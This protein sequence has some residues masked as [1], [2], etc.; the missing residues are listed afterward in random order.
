MKSASVLIVGGGIVGASIAWHLA[1]RGWRDI[2]IADRGASPGTGSSARSLGAFR[3]NFG[4]Q[5]QVRLALLSRAKLERFREETG[6]DA[7]YDDAGHLWVASSAEDLERLREGLRVQRSEGVLSVRELGPDDVRRINPALAEDGIV[8]G[9]YCP[10]DGFFQPLRVLEGYLAAAERRGV[11]TRWGLDVQGFK[12]N[13]SRRI[14]AAITSEGT[15]RVG[16]VVNAAGPWATP[17]ADRAGVALPVLP[18]RRQVLAVR[19]AAEL[20]PRMPMTTFVADGLQCRCR[21]VELLVSQP[22]P[23]I[24]GRPWDC[25]VEPAWIESVGQLARE[26]FTPLASASFE[27]ASSWA[28]LLEISPDH[29]VVLGAA[30]ECEN[31]YMANGAS[32]HGAMLAPA[33]GQLLAEVMTDGETPALDITSLRLSRFSESAPN[34]P[35]VLP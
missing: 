11:R 21:D 1:E 10:L 6:G 30:P 28:G 26:R 19:L 22:A 31:F 13:A 9:A 23:G 3:A 4:S 24:R 33:L 7:D 12:R 16:A 18:L 15:M 32:G 29:H 5:M 2:V 8:G 14:T 34:P 25:T 35:P 27:G 17:L 20:P